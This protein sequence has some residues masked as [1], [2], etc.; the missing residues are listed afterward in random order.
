VV[1]GSTVFR[2]DHY[3][4]GNCSSRHATPQNTSPNL[5]EAEHDADEWQAAM[6]V[7]NRHVERA[8]NPIIGDG[9]SWRE[10]ND[11]LYPPAKVTAP[12]GQELRPSGLDVAGGSRPRIN[13]DI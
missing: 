3:R 9:A 12:A 8:F 13:S 7:L 5:P 4:V 11:R 10:M 6:Q 2:S 1:E